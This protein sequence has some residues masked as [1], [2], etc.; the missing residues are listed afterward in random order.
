MEKESVEKSYNSVQCEYLE[1][2]ENVDRLYDAWQNASF[3]RDR[4]KEKWLG[5]KLLRTA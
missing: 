2:C 1:A 4:K 3:D 5:K